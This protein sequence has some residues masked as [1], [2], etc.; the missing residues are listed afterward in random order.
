MNDRLDTSLMPDYSALRSKAEWNYTLQNY[1]ETRGSL[2]LAIA[3]VNLFWPE[4]V[5]YQGCIIRRDALDPQTFEKWWQK[6]NGDRVAVEK[7]MNFLHVRDIAPND[8]SAVDTTLVRFLGERMAEMW[9]QR[10]QRQFPKL[11]F[12]AWYEETEDTSDGSVFL[13]QA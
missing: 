13:C 12:R 1:I 5:E 11:H 7:M 3:F 9:Q 4:F 8:D 6:C 10:A 2:E